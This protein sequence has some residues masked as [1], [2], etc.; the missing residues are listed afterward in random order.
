MS[1]EAN[2]NQNP[3]WTVDV[4]RGL[5]W[6]IVLLFAFIV[7]VMATRVAISAAIEDIGDVLKS[8]LAVLFNIVMLILGFFFGSSKSS[9]VKDEQ[10]AKT[11]E[12]LA[13]KVIG[14][15]PVDPTPPTTVVTT[16]PAD[17]SVTATI[18]TVTTQEPKP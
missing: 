1:D 12:K 6:T 5:A 10:Q 15:P 11:A 16:A 9:Q 3:L 17:P 4:Q 14:P 8:A 13:E 7:S 18:T 2:D